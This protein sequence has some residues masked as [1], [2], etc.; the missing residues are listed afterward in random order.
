MQ[1]TIESTDAITEI[2][3]V[4]ARLWEGLTEGGIPCKVFVHRIAVAHR[5]DSS[6]FDAELK[7]KLPPA[8]PIPLS[9]IL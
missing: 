7:E 9:M 3:G 6:A 4:E 2:T 8:R 5:E 1:I